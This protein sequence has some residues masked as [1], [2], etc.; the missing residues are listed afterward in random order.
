MIKPLTIEEQEAVYEHYGVELYDVVCSPLRDENNP[1]FSTYE[2]NGV[3]RWRDFGMGEGGNV[4]DFIISKEG[5][6]FLGSKKIIQDILNNNTVKHVTTKKTAQPK[7]EPVRQVFHSLQWKTSELAYFN[8]RGITQE[9]LEKENIFPLKMLMIDGKFKTTSI[10]DNPKFVYYLNNIKGKSWKIYSPYDPEYKWI[11]N[12]IDVLMLEDM[13]SFNFKDLIIFSS[14][15]DKMVFNNLYLN[16]DTT[17]LLAE[18]NFHRLISNLC[19][20]EY[21]DNI[22]CLLDF[23]DAGVNSSDK[24]NILSFGRIR[25]LYLPVEKQNYYYS[26][27][28]KDIDEMYTEEG[29]KELET[30]IKQ[31][32]DGIDKA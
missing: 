15:K 9:Q 1:S 20:L 12:N 19:K 24:L 8:K 6:N 27:D 29:P 21:Y 18:G 26:K 5:C 31:I 13:P 3:V 4:Y 14:K 2:R 23:D 30:T 17:S 25:P 10:P 16:Y 11:S 22:Y 7:K 28:I 32:L